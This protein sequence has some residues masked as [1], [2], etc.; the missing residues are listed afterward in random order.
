MYNYLS[1]S[2][3]LQCNVVVLYPEHVCVVDGGSLVN[4]IKTYVQNKS[5]G[6]IYRI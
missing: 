3:F 5:A 1:L 6:T 2:L 4:V